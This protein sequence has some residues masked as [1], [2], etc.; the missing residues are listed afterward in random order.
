MNIDAMQKSVDLILM[1]EDQIENGGY[2]MAL[3]DELQDI[4]L[5]PDETLM[6]EA[7]IS[8]LKGV[9]QLPGILVFNN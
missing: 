7:I 3:F 5:K 4:E 1:I 8:N 9:N 6:V 2:D